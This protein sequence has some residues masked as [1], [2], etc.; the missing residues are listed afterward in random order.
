MQ[1]KCFF[2]LQSRFN[3]L[4]NLIMHY[5]TLRKP[6]GISCGS[7]VYKSHI[8]PII[9]LLSWKL[10]WFVT[11]VLMKI[12]VRCKKPMMYFVEVSPQV[13]MRIAKI[14]LL[15]KNY[16]LK[17]ILITLKTTFWSIRE[18]L[19]EVWRNFKYY[20]ILFAALRPTLCF[21]SS[22]FSYHFE[23]SFLEQ[24]NISKDMC[25]CLH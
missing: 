21:S 20:F 14:C 13:G 24:W 5:K 2:F 15:K 16:K 19:S 22:T 7:T 11:I 1:E 9:H 18:V 12:D 4:T 6:W 17:P 10:I 25:D 3:L 8:C 23:C